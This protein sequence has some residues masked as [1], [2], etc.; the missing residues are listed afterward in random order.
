MS[1]TVLQNGDVTP[2][3][4]PYHGLDNQ[5]KQTVN[6]YTKSEFIDL[7]YHYDNWSKKLK[8]LG[9]NDLC[10]CGSNKKYKKCCIRKFDHLNLIRFTQLA[11]TG[12]DINNLNEEDVSLYFDMYSYVTG[13]K[14]NDFDQVTEVRKILF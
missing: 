13:K 8:H 2:I 4:N 14:I 7:F 10:G 9:R 5:P 6:F 11:R 3:I 1:K 12:L